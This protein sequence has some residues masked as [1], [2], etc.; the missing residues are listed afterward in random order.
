ME[1]VLFP[2]CMFQLLIDRTIDPATVFT[3]KTEHKS[4]NTP[5]SHITISQQHNN[6][7]VSQTI[8]IIIDHKI[9]LHQ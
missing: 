5:F 3:Q 8:K 4:P 9:K 1:M 6:Y 2:L 7:S